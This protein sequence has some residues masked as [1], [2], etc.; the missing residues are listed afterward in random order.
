VFRLIDFWKGVPILLIR[1]S[2]PGIC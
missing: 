2:W 1:C